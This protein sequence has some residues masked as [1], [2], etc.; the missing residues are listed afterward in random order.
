[1]AWAVVDIHAAPLGM[2]E[3]RAPQ[4]GR[5]VVERQ[6]KERRGRSKKEVLNPWRSGSLTI[7]PPS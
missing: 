1:V 4:L 6:E 5:L 7:R 3:A 2:K